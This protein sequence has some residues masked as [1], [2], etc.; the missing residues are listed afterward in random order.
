MTFDKKQFLEELK[1]LG[2]IEVLE[3]EEMWACRV[4]DEILEIELVQDTDVKT[5]DEVEVKSEI[6]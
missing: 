3:G 5:S 4:V 2:D 6:R 1:S